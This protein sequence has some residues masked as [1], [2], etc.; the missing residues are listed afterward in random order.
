MFNASH[1]VPLES[2]NGNKFDVDILIKCNV[3]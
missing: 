2:K 3:K 1:L